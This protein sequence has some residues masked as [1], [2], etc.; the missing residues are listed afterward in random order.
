MP[1]VGSAG[2]PTAGSRTP[3]GSLGVARAAPPGWVTTGLGHYWAQD[4]NER[5]QI[6]LLGPQYEAGGR[7][8]SYLWSNGRMRDLGTLPLDARDAPNATVSGG[9]MNERGEIIGAV[10]VNRDDSFSFHAFSWY[11][12]KMRDLGCGQRTRTQCRDISS[13]AYALNERGQSVGWWATGTEATTTRRRA[14]LWHEGTTRFL[15]TLPGRG[16]SE[17]TGINERGEIIGT[18]YVLDN[19]HGFVEQRREQAF[20]W[21]NGTMRALLLPGDD[22]SWV[23]AINDRSQAIGT[24][25][26]ESSEHPAFFVCRGFLWDNGTMRDLRRFFPQ[27]INNRGQMLGSDDPAHNVLQFLWDGG[28]ITKVEELGLRHATDIN[29][30]G[31]IVGIVETAEGARAALWH[32]GTLTNLGALSGARSSFPRQITNRGQILGSSQMPADEGSGWAEHDHS[33]LWT[34]FGLRDQES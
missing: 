3:S 22:I 11:R 20:I 15:G 21:K 14:A 32:D 18:S 4:I 25:C 13:R 26:A 19:R 12:G 1:V 16:S 27:V 23:H 33:M 10:L 30:S 2:A 6:V 34:R 29:D 28:R 31:D 17:A 9:A 5:G 7:W 24:S 8:R